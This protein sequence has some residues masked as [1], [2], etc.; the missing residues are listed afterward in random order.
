[1]FP[2]NSEM[3]TSVAV[4]ETA[5]WTE[6]VA[7][8]KWLTWM[9]IVLSDVTAVT[10]AGVAAVFLRL[11]WGG[12]FKPAEYLPFALALAL[13]LLMF[14]LVG[15]YPGI[16]LNPVQE[17]RRIVSAV[18]AVFLVLLSA[19]FLLGVSRDYS[20]LIFLMAWAASIVLVVTFRNLLRGMLVKCAW[21]GVPVVVFGTGVTAR[22]V[23]RTL[24][25]HSSLGL[26]VI[27]MLDDGEAS[28]EQDHAPVP[29]VGGLEMAPVVAYTYGVR[30]AVMAMP[31]ARTQELAAVIRRYGHCF[32]HVLIVPDLFDVSSLWV[33]AKDLGGMLGL[34]LTQTLTQTGPQILKRSVDLLVALIGG[35]L[36]LPLIGTISLAICLTTRIAV[37]YEQERIGKDGVPFRV[38]KFRTMVADAGK[39]LEEYLAQH[40]EARQ[41]WEANQ[42]LRHDP[43][44]TRIG[45]I[46]RKT[47]LD[48]L[49]QIW[50]I[51]RGDMSLVGPR[52]ILRSE[53]PRWGHDFE[54]Y[55]KVRPGITGLWQVSGRSN[56]TYHE[57]VQFDGY[58]VRNWSVWL[59]LY[60]L[61]RT[62]QTVLAAE[63]AC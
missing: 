1:M 20:R 16:A 27:A 5:R 54:L 56:T 28:E 49:P 53:I 3:T 42:K 18:T 25:K 4:H 23:V 61:G 37:F 63:G 15:L 7:T 12:H 41:E 17:F 29:V 14:S 38:W 2:T 51:I 24:Q 26:K 8:R 32:D 55:R 40:P 31:V 22:K 45:R 43:R 30:Y 35:S 34:E 52:P 48:E 21:W 60:I 36:I 47:S 62:V 57:R 39:V 46:L 13:F 58:Y 33:S 10:L 9:P 11:A 6:G 59:D 50:N 19:T 44:V